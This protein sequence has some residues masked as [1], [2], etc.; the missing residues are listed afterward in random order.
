M[1]AALVESFGRAPRYGEM[2]E[3]EAGE[4]E[5][6]LEVRAAALTNLVRGQANGSHYSA[7]GPMPFVP[8]NDGVGLTEAGKRVYFVGPRAPFGSMA[9]RTAVD[10]RRMIAVP[11][12]LDDVTAA[13][14]GNPGLATWGALLGRAKMV[15][16]DVVLVNGAT[17]AAGQQAVQVA[18]YLGAAKVIAT[19]RNREVLE[20]IRGLGA[21]ETVVLGDGEDVR[22][23]LGYWMREGGVTVVLDYL[24]GPT[25]AMLLHGAAGRGSMAGERR[26]RY[27]QIGSIGGATV[28]LEGAVLRSSGLEVLGSG[29][30]SLG[31]AEIVEALTRM[32][33][34]AGEHRFAIE[35]EAVRLEEVEAAW[36]RKGEG[37][38]VF[39]V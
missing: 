35:T 21:D 22:E 37:R 11:E 34:A 19:G 2:R 18:K 36:G 8:G 38:V 1:R 9:Q 17:G 28:Q 7:G 5:V 16:G 27:V 26:I 4:G 25:A 13:A 39:V 31:A 14:L 3:P 33:A 10:R 23:R 30:G 32:F 15:P 20:R 12:G 24:W 29:L 6:V